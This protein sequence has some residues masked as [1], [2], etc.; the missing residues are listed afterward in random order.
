MRCP[1]QPSLQTNM[2]SSFK[3]Y[4][5]ELNSQDVLKFLA[6][7]LMVIDH[8]GK[9][10]YP[11]ILWF[12]V[13]GRL[14]IPIWFFFVG[15]SRTQA[16]DTPIIAGAMVLVLFDAAM[17]VAIFPLNILFTVMCCRIIHRRFL[18]DYLEK[19]GAYEF[20]LLLGMVM[21][22]YL[23]SM[24]M[25]EYGTLAL[26]FTVLGRLLREGNKT[27]NTLVYACAAIV[28]FTLLQAYSF[29]FSLLQG[30]ILGLGI[31]LMVI[32]LYHY[33]LV[34]YPVSCAHPIAAPVMFLAR[35]SLYFY[36]LHLI[37]LFSID[38]VLNPENYAGF[39][40]IN[41]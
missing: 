13:V 18:N 32:L 7:L 38:R 15:Y 9:F 2:L 17:H 10:F 23:P 29:K 27:A 22:F 25:V 20:I 34:H 6:L 41:L 40:W 3:K 33:R 4:G 1:Y 8:I 28:I 11:D 26:L 21:L 16:N 39:K 12:R 24:L 5:T 37:I 35:N 19:A 30:G 31:S 14:C 36:V